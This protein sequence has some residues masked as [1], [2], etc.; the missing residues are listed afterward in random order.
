MRDVMPEHTKTVQ[1]ECSACDGTGLGMA[2]R[3][4]FAVQCYHCTGTGREALTFRWRDFEGRKRREGVLQVLQANPGVDIDTGSVHDFGG[5]SVEAWERGDPFGPGTEMRAFAC[6]A[7][8]FQTA[9]CDKKPPYWKECNDT[10][11]RRFSDCRH[12]PT[13]AKCWARWDAEQES[14]PEAPTP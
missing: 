5:L 14:A 1:A 3:D 8:W 9:D 7:W 10:L 4:G 2:G 11:G 12:F 13:K 6:P